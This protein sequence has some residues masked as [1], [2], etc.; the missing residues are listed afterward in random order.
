MEED[1][2]PEQKTVTAMKDPEAAFYK[3]S[4]EAILT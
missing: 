4:S 2:E 3:D 1:S